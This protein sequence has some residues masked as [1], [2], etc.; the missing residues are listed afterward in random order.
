[1]TE[2]ICDILVIG[3][4]PAGA[5]AAKKA[6]EA[7]VRVIL[8][9]RKEVIGEPVRCAEY[10]PRQLLGEMDCVKDFIVQ[11]VK[12]MKSILPDNSIEESPS[13]GLIINRNIFDRALI[14]KAGKAGAEIWN[15]TRALAFNDDCVQ[16]LKNR[17]QIRIKARII[18][19]ADGPHSRVGRWIGSSNKNLVPAVQVRV[20]LKEPA[21]SSEVYFDKRFFVLKEVKCSAFIFS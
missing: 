1:M 18:I 21:E 11:P 20:T 19:G 3:A 4:G 8:I 7:G 14:E 6:A 2:I 12:S 15:N 13:P 10:I 9:D 16:A 5:S 17:K